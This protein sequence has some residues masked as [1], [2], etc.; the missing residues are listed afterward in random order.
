MFGKSFKK[1]A[2]KEELDRVSA[3][4]ETTLGDFTVE[5]LPKN[6]QKLFGTLSIWLKVAK[7]AL[8]MA[9]IMMA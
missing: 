2:H 9:H 5:L 1:N 7:K 3:K 4:F 6:V 8:K